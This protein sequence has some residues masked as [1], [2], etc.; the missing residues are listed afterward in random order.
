MRIDS[1]DEKYNNNSINLDHPI[2]NHYSKNKSLESDW[3]FPG[4]S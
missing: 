2:L 3:R 1:I 4:P